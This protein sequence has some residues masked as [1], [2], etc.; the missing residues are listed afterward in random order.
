ME[1]HW[2]RV[3]HYLS[4]VGTNGITLNPAKFKFCQKNI[5]FAGFV[6]S[7]DKAKAGKEILKVIIV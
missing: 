7:M 6:V 5:K 1:V 2:W 4:L 3:L